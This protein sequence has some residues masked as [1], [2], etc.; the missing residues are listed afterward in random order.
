MNKFIRAFFYGNIFLGICAVA[1]CIETNLLTNISL[2]IFPF[3]L[4]I[5]FC[6]CIYYTM[7]YVRSVGAKNYNDRTLWYRKNLIAIKT[8]LKYSIVLAFIFLSFLVWKNLHTFLLLSPLQFLLI[9][10][11][12]LIAGWYTFAP[13]LFRIRKIRQIGWIKPFVVGLTWAG[14]V[15]IY[16][17][18]IW[19]VQRSLLP[20]FTLFSLLLLW[21]ENFLFFSV[22]AIIF[23]IKD[24]RTD[25]RHHLNTYPVLLG[26]RNTFRFIVIPVTILNLVVFFLFQWQENFSLVQTFIQLIPYLLLILIIV[27]YRQGRSVLYYL[28]AVDGLVFAKALCGITSIL[29]FKK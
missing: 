26:I 27:K 11:F 5:F 19:N 3:Y 8:T 29:F 14:W 10:A 4:L 2:N 15:T 7:I 22:N 9:L 12:P 23:D 28:V 17:V 1:L 16:P 13:R 20:T 18:I 25:S 24:Y 6:T 21:L